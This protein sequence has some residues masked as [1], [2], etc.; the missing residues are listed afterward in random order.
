MIAVIGVVVSTLAPPLVHQT[1]QLIAK[2][3][4]FTNELINGH[5][6]ASEQIRAYHLADRIS[7]SQAQ[8]VG[9]VSSAG[10][11]AIP[12][13]STAFSKFGAVLTTLVLAF[14]MMVEGPAWY[15]AFSSVLPPARRDHT[16]QLLAHMYKAITG[17]V[18]GY[19]LLT[20]LAATLT[21]AVLVIVGVPYAIPLGLLVGIF[22]FLPLVGASIGAT[23]VIAASLGHSVAAAVIM[24]I[25]FAI[26][27]QIENHILQPLVQGRSVQMSALSVIVS[28]LLGAGLGG[29]IGA[30][31]AIP[32][33][34]CIQILVR[35]MIASRAQ[36]TSE[37]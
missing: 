28:V 15:R 21:A 27:Q 17:Y 16:L 8:I 26:Y 35:D 2:F 11:A 18:M 5:S 14:F 25:F 30:F 32:V 31:V 4:A 1:G 24:F 22:D 36:V 13:V 23:I 37:P 12:L 3:P 19:L 33:G 7:Q 20:G 29:L 9:Y 34:A 10:G 6:A